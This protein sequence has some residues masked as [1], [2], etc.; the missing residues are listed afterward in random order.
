MSLPSNIIVN[1]LQILS[2]NKDTPKWMCKH[3]EAVI[4][5]FEKKYYK[6]IVCCKKGRV[7]Y[8]IDQQLMLATVR[9]ENK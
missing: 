4:V 9:D 6:C 7:I 5:N 2:T 3:S 1:P 8:K